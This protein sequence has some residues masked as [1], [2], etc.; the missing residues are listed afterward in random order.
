MYG[1]YIWKKTRITP[2]FQLIFT[3]N[4]SVFILVL[5]SIKP[6]FAVYV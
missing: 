1:M 3:C 4:A 5:F 6:I 2:E